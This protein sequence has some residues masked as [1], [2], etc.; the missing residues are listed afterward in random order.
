MTHPVV[1]RVHETAPEAAVH[2]RL[3]GLQVE[4]GVLDGVTEGEG[5]VPH[6]VQHLYT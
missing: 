1:D 4:P 5:L 6:A 3:S 2:H